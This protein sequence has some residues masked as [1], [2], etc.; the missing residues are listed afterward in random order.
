MGTLAA[1]MTASSRQQVSQ[2]AVGDFGMRIAQH[3]VVTYAFVSTL[4]SIIAPEKAQAQLCTKTE[5]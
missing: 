1:D 3:G 4:E 5:R 2:S